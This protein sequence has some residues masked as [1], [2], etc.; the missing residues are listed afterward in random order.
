MAVDGENC[1]N[2]RLLRRL[3]NMQKKLKIW[4][5]YIAPQHLLTRF[6]G[7]VAEN[8]IV[9]FKNMLIRWFIGK[10]KVDLKLAR[11]EKVEDYAN[12][13]QF[14]IRQLKPELRP[15]VEGTKNIACPVDGAVSQMGKIHKDVLFQAKGF[16]FHL[17]ELLGGSEP[18]AKTFYNGEFATIYLAPKDYH[19]VHMPLSGE[20]RETIYI[21][22]KLFSVNQA[23]VSEVPQLFSRNERLVCLFE[24][25]VGPM[26]VIM[27]GAMIVGNMK[28]V[29]PLSFHPNRIVKKFYENMVRLEKGAELGY[30]KLGSTV[31]VLFP[32]DVMEWEKGLKENSVLQM[33]K[34]LGK[35][36]E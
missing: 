18:H 33:G 30:F 24:T 8:R 1:Y 12:F 21:P 13:N 20:L 11:L 23:T 3:K 28:T 22:G 14:F 9:W 27:I 17:N 19:R 32:K 36:F 2:L 31:I 26:A 7:L 35:V 6:A 4:L 34:L 10:Y 15:I 25:A 16:Y 5:Q 29:W